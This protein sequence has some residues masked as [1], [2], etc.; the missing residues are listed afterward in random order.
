MSAHEWCEKED[1]TSMTTTS[2]WHLQGL[3]TQDLKTSDK[4]IQCT[5]GRKGMDRD[6]SASIASRGLCI[7]RNWWGMP[8]RLKETEGYF[9]TGSLPVQPQV[10]MGSGLVD[11]SCDSGRT[12]LADVDER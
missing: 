11:P 6:P 1:S 10:I 9:R 3:H 2:R 12:V 5:S 8:P 4:N 7:L